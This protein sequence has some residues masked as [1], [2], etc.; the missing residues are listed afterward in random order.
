MKTI[1]QII[2]EK[3]K[4]RGWTL[5]VLADKLG[6]GFS[7]ISAWE[8]GKN[9]PTLFT[10]CDLADIFECTLDELCGREVKINEW[11]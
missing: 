9:I 6:V 5:R 2:K 3:R 1:G 4:E 7:L 11:C 8:R 10:A